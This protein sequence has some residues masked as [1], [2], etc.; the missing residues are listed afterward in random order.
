MDEAPPVDPWDLWRRL[1]LSFAMLVAFLATLDGVGITGTPVADTV[2]GW[3]TPEA[4]LLSPAG[5]A[6]AIWGVIQTGV[7]LHFIHQWLP[8]QRTNPRFR[9]I[10]WWLSASVLVYSGWLVASQQGWLDATSV[11]ILVLALLLGRTLA[12]LQR[13][14]RALAP[15]PTRTRVIE[16]I[17]T[18]AP[19]GLFLGW[20][21][22]ASVPNVTAS[23]MNRGL[24]PSGR[25]AEAIAL[26]M[27]AVVLALS[28]IIQGSLRGRWSISLAMAW[29]LAWV[30]VERV[31]GP[32][33]SLLVALGAA[34]M[35]ILV[36]GTGPLSRRSARDDERHTGR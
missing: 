23:L 5:S 18:D 10:G 3:F 27:L 2:D 16:T 4:T 17:T 7:T 29:G 26:V 6:F 12:V 24:D 34:G 28:I 31:Q 36:A 11:L 13:T 9:A 32:N 30:A 15:R 19:L 14:Q 8:G 25:F 33:H 21:S 35:A 1:A 22:L 20:V